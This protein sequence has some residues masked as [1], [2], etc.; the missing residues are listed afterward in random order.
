MEETSGGASESAMRAA[1]ELRVVVGRL[2]RRLRATYATTELTPSQASVLS[3][4]DHDGDASVT[5]LASA[6]RVRHQSMATTVAALEERGLVTRRPDP[7]DG[8]RHV[9]SLSETGRKY[10]DDR[11]RA[12]EEWLTQ[13]LEAHLTEAEHHTVIEA[14]A[15]LERL[16]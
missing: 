13:A 3:R 12:G 14:M 5:D 10:L 15:L 1:H 16:A 6:E 7:D 2:K 4:L 9:L 11:R 8:R